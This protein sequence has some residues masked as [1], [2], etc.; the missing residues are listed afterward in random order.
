MTG[1]FCLEV[2]IGLLVVTM[3]R[4]KCRVCSISST[5]MA[6]KWACL[7]ELMVFAL[8]LATIRHLLFY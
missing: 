8:T 7:T 1:Y 5:V 4:I 2:A 3:V 6:V